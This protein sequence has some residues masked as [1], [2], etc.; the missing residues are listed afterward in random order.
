MVSEKYRWRNIE[1]KIEVG[2]ELDLIGDLEFRMQL[3][4]ELKLG[5]ETG[6][7]RECSFVPSSLLPLAT[8]LNS[9][10]ASR[11]RWGPGDMD[12]HGHGQQEEL[13]VS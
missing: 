7:A 5:L 9:Q 1:G 10:R 6:K 2:V 13:P 3:E 4:L 11:A 8:S 12:G